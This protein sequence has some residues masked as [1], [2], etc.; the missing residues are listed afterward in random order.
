VLFGGEAARTAWARLLEL[1][2]L[3]RLQVVVAESSPLCRSGWIGILALDGTVTASVPDDD[4][5]APVEAALIALSPDDA[6]HVEVVQS[7]LP[8]TRTVLGPVPLFYLPQ[9]Y[10]AGENAHAE[11][12]SKGELEGFATTAASDELD[13]SGILNVT[14]PVFASRTDAGELAAV[15]GYRRW[16]NDVAHLSALTAPSHRQQ[17][18]GRSAALAAITHAIESGLLP[19]WRARPSASQALARSLGL[20]RLG[21]QLNF[22]PV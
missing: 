9:G 3:A 18:H 4:L 10:T 8:A 2:G 13:E 16:P 22:D 19:Q 11:Q 21:A 5:R 15:C 17:G 14:S 6:V 20:T 1:E 7:R 12:V